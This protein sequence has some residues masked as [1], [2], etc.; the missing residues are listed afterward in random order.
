[1]RLVKD[2][3][4]KSGVTTLEHPPY[5]PDLAAAD[6]YLYPRLKSTLKGRPFY[7]TT[8]VIKNATD[9]LNKAFTKWSPGMFPKNVR[10]LEE[11]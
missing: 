2:F 11:V 10:T 7:D 3:L 5:S 4:A 1:M 8:G 9:E 6:F